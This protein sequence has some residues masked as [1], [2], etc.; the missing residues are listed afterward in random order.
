MWSDNVDIS[1]PASAPGLTWGDG[2]PGLGSLLN[3]FKG[4]WTS[5]PKDFMGLILL[6]WVIPA[7]YTL[8]N[9]FFIGRM[10]M[11]AIA[12]S[13]QY[14]NVAV[15][16]EILLEM[17]PLAVLALVA[18][19]LTKAEKVANVLRSAIVMQLV[20]TTAFLF[21]I[22]IGTGLFVEAINTPVD[23]QL[24]TEAFLR[25]K[26]LAIPFE[27]LGILF[28]VAIKAM[29]RGGLAVGIAAVGVLMNVVLDVFLIS[30]FSFSLRLGLI[31]SAW[32]YVATKV[33]VFLVAAVVFYAVVRKKPDLRLD[34]KEAAGILRI[35][36]YTG[37]ESAVRNAGYILGVLIVLNTL[38]P[39]EYGGY[40]VAMTIMW[41]IF[42]VPVLALG[43]ATNVAIGNEYGERDLR[44][45]KDVHLVS[46]ML[47]GGYMAVMMLLGVV[48]WGP[49][50]SFFNTNASVVTYSTATYQYLAIPYVL[51]AV[52]TALRSLFIGTGKTFYYLVPSAAL[53]LGI[54]IPLG[55][56]VKAGAVAPTFDQLMT[57][58]FA[59]FALDLVITSALVRRQYRE[60]SVELG[61]GG[62][63]L[64][65]AGSV[66]HV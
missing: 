26:A 38:G 57:I 61:V 42:L 52:G 30:D 9:T 21:A 19:D 11:E 41:L 24:R 35:G 55:L 18:R 51:F 34:K 46:L 17:F 47:M 31:G 28:I 14:E 65:A 10:E 48:L 33:V 32:G 56:L 60:L 3:R 54:Y 15:I 36:R 6:A 63:L 1:G 8:A 40:G 58:T 53:N 7:V 59:V 37:L 43:E 20:V 27:A 16:L 39:A 5:Y 44:G 64:G 12:I 62:E 50:S 29:R 2:I 45:M 66:V 49:L 13:E 25:V 23:M 22:L 4:A